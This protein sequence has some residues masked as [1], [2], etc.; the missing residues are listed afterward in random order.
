MRR[1]AALLVL[2]FAAACFAQS[3][4]RPAITGIAFVRFYTAHTPASIIFYAHT[5]GLPRTVQDGVSR[6][7]VNNSQ[8]V[9]VEPFPTPAPASPLAAI[10]FTTRDAAALQTYLKAHDVAIVQP[11]ANGTFGV[12]DPE[13]HLILFVQSDTPRIG[14]VPRPILL[15]P[16]H[17]II[18]AG[19]I[20]KN[21]EAEDHFY[22]DILGFRPYWHGG[23]T[24]T[25]TDYV[26]IQVPDGTDWVEYMLNVGPNPSPKTIGVLDHFSLGVANMPDAIKMLARTGCTEPSCSASKVGVDGKTQ[27]NLYDP[28]LTRAEIME[29]APVAKPCCSPFTGKH[30]SEIEDK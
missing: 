2:L 10:A 24:E 17:R 26:S 9:E 16:S 15:S 5:L 18:H 20:V 3:Q 4:Q 19:F 30:P 21:R 13:G 6:Y 8:W 28:D 12:K 11:L 14:G 29:F 23:K 25:S 7:S 22:R 27:L 1:R